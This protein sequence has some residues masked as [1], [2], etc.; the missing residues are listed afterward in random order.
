MT[1][2]CGPGSTRQDELFQRSQI[3]V[4]LIYGTLQVVNLIR[5]NHGVIR[6]AKLSS[7]IEKTMLD[8]FQCAV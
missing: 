1:K 2:C 8:L 7:Q 6:D 5:L 3:L 4:Q